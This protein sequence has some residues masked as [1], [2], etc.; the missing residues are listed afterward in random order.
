MYLVLTISICSLDM[1]S[2]PPTHTLVSGFW[3]RALPKGRAVV[4]QA[5]HTEESLEP[6]GLPSLTQQLCHCFRNVFMSLLAL[7]LR[8]DATHLWV[9]IQPTDS[10]VALIHIP[11]R[12]GGTSRPTPYTAN[13]KYIYSI[14]SSSGYFKQYKQIMKHLAEN[15]TTYYRHLSHAIKLSLKLFLMAIVGIVHAVFPFIFPNYVSSGVKAMDK[16]VDIPT[17]WIIRHIEEWNV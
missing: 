12:L 11:A 17:I 6:I 4:N 16:S 7:R 10:A 1:I 14:H 13:I 2:F 15:N 3:V 5:F 9:S 8:G